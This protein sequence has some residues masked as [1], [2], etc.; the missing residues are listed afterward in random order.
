M[1]MQMPV[2]VPTMLTLTL[3]LLLTKTIATGMQQ[4]HRWRQHSCMSGRSAGGRMEKFSALVQP[5]GK[6]GCVGMCD[7]SRDRPGRMARRICVIQCASSC[8][9]LMSIKRGMDV[10]QAPVQCVLA[11][12]P[13]RQGFKAGRICVAQAV[14]QGRPVQAED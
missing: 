1:P 8:P 10:L 9:I 2:L 12:E 11:E 3:L 14:G 5:L 4:R 6:Y 7:G 13:T